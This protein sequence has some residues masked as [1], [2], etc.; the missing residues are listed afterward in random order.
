MAGRATTPKRAKELLQEILKVV[1]LPGIARR[2][3]VARGNLTEV[4]PL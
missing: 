2:E 3:L 1:F 4:N